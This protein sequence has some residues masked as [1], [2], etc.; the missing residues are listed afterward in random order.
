MVNKNLKKIIGDGIGDACD[1]CPGVPNP[2]QSDQDNDLVGDA[3]D[4]DIDRDF[5]GIQDSQGNYLH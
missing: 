1:N 2:S 4:S 3:C 5:D